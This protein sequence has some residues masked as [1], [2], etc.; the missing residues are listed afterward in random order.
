MCLEPLTTEQLLAYWLVEPSENESA[1]IEEHLF[2][3]ASCSASLERL[4]SLGQGVRNA[5]R[6]G[7]I[8][9]VLPSSFVE[10]LKSAGLR[11]REYRLEPQGS[12]NCTVTANDDLV[13]AH[14][15]APLE[16]VQRLDAVLTDLTD[17]SESRLADVSFNTNEGEVVLLPNTSQLRPVQSTTQRVRLFALDE[18][19]ERMIGEY[20][21]RHYGSS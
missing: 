3:C 10:R 14:L 5:L 12:V 8:A 9:A 1:A 20:L 19:G 6:A 2:G 4:V 16:G 11:V 21:F 17:G 18:Q 13:L 7:D 15:R